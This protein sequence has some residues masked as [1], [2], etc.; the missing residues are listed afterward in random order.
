MIV[1]TSF[2][3]IVAVVLESLFGL[4]WWDYSNEALNF[5]GRISLPYS[6][7]WGIVGVIFVEKIH[8]YVKRKIEKIESLI[9]D[10]ILIILLYV[11]IVIIIVDFIASIVKYVNI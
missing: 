7:A 10:K 8:P 6:I 9:S 3:Y 1:F 4:R 11:S 5:Q 2:E